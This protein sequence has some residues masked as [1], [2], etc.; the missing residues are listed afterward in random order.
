[1]MRRLDLELAE[2]IQPRGSSSDEHAFP[3]APP[4]FRFEKLT[5]KRHNI[6]DCCF[7][8]DYVVK[9]AS[10]GTYTLSFAYESENINPIMGIAMA[11]IGFR[12][13]A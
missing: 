7:Q 3:K 12:G 8:I 1:M 9:S 13:S 4:R 6:V 11:N 5:S 10:C 2:G